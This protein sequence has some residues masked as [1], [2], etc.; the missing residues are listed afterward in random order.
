M[1]AGTFGHP[2]G[3]PDEWPA[4]GETRAMRV[5]IHRAAPAGWLVLAALPLPALAADPSPAS[6]AD[7]GAATLL[8][9]LLLG[10]LT[11]GLFFASPF[12]RRFGRGQFASTGATLAADGAG[13]MTRPVGVDALNRL[14]DTIHARLAAL[15]SRWPVMRTATPLPP[16]LG[17]DIFYDDEPAAATAPAQAPSAVRATPWSTAPVWAQRYGPFR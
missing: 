14:A 4:L 16:M 6:S 11:A 13:G 9:V 15:T 5:V 8:V 2:F 3:A 12:R 7:G 10:S 1:G 17:G